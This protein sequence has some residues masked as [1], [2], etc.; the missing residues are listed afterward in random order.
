MVIMATSA[1][2]C[3]ATAAWVGWNG[4]ADARISLHADAV[5]ITSGGERVAV[6]I[7]SGDVLLPG[8][9]VL[10]EADDAQELAAE[11]RSWVAAGTM[12]DIGPEYADMIQ[13]ALL[14]LHTLTLKNGATLAGWSSSWRYVWPRDAAFVATALARTDHAADAQQIMLFLEAVQQNDGLFYGRYRPDGVGAGA[15]G[16]GIQLDGTGWAL[17]AI[18]QIA[19]TLEPTQ[20]A[21]FLDSVKPLLVRSTSAAL[22]LID[23]EQT[24]PPPS[25][26]FWEL[27]EQEL[28]LGT[29][30]PLLA[31][32]QAARDVY[33]E[34]GWTATASRAAQGSRRLSLAIEKAF[35]SAGYP[36][37]PHGTE[38]D[39]SIMFLLPPIGSTIDPAVVS[40]WQ[41]AQEMMRRPAGGL[42]PG[43]GWRDDGVSWTPPT[44]MYAMT[45]AALGA[46]EA[47]LETLSWLNVHRTALGALPEKVLSNGRPAAVAPL[48]WT[49]AIV[50]I[51]ADELATHR[52]GIRSAPE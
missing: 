6:P 7:G 8:S 36:R 34:L 26:D 17:W 13:M 37:Y 3:T 20:R 48:G 21:A 39:A 25:P 18:A 35:G 50:I 19:A 22:K 24:L 52:A 46:D 33:D 43:V 11:Q 41:S 9:R 44:A 51:A 2:L 14:D 49:A 5:A 1:L 4:A 10:T 30:A 16:R 45:S 29:A 15:D 32:L 47:A 23:N 27:D 28:T 38:P 31:G 42:A 12:P 40:A